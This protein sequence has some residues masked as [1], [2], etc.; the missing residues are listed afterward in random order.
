MHTLTIKGSVLLAFLFHSFLSIAQ[1]NN[2]LIKGIQELMLENY[3]FLDKAKETNAHLD[4]LMK[5]N[6]FDA[7]TDAEKLA[8]EVTT[9]MR[10]ITKDKHL[11]MV[12]PRNP[13]VRKEKSEAS[14]IR[15]FSRYYNP[16]LNEYKYYDGNVAYFDMRYFGGP[17]NF[18]K[19]DVIMKQLSQADAFIIDMR[20]N[21]GGSPRMVQYIC[22]HFFDTHLLLNSIYTRATDHME[23]LWTVD[24]KGKKR[25]KVPVFILTSERTFSAAE[26]F[27]YTMQSR[28]RATIIGEV[29]GGGAHPTRYF[30]LSD[31][32][33]I[34]IPFARSINPVTK[35][36]WEG[37]GVIPDEKVAATEALD[38]ALELA[39]V[40]AE[41]YRNSFFQ[42]LK[43]V[44]DGMA[45]KKTNEGADAVHKLLEASVKADILNERDI[46]LIGYDYLLGGKKA[47]AL[48]V[49][50][51]N[52]TLFSDSANAYDSYAEGLEKAGKKE[53]ALANYEKAVALAAEQEHRNLEAFKGNL[54]RFKKKMK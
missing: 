7:Y 37:T 35:T 21:G 16:M 3:V 28:K 25:P 6:H 51:S 11:R 53:K 10:K 34:R 49:F 15:N 12:A 19:I 22:S 18:P 32:F 1:S 14:F 20:K 38:K 36:N 33:G 17:D 30:P 29:T 5:K 23:E 48:A 40:A 54:E 27:S 31:G 39:T 52:I 9:Q 26:D 13:Q 2:D 44:L 41:E 8:K 50:K 45:D 24:V 43:K 47:A 46:N 4:A 42:P